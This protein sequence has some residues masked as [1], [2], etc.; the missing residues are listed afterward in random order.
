MKVKYLKNNF[1]KLKA[2]CYK[3]QVKSKAATEQWIVLSTLSF[4]IL[5][6]LPLLTQ[7]SL[8]KT[9]PLGK[10]FWKIKEIDQIMEGYGLGAICSVEA[11]II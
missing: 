3:N 9:L 1:K 5:E 10:V 8:E 2:K 4:V 6:K 11:C 7:S